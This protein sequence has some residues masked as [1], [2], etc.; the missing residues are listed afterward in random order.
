MV[1]GSTTS[2]RPMPPKQRQIHSSLFGFDLPS[3][4]QME[5]GDSLANIALYVA[6]EYGDFT[7]EIKYFHKYILALN[8]G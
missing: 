7:R 5:V 4:L 2:A 6:A 8:A 3:S 1:I